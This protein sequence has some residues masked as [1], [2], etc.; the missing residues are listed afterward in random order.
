MATFAQII[1]VTDAPHPSSWLYRVVIIVIRLCLQE[2]KEL[3]QFHS[4]V[5][6]FSFHTAYY[7]EHLRQMDLNFT[8][9]KRALSSFAKLAASYILIYWKSYPNHLS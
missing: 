8:E 9:H 6:Y 4:D 3:P 5:A 1:C 7:E 2:R